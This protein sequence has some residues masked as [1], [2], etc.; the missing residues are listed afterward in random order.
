M[1]DETRESAA[2]LDLPVMDYDNTE[3]AIEAVDAFYDQ[4][5]GKKMS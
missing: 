4:L 3:E 2:K 1:S 5:L